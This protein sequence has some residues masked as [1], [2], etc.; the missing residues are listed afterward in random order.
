MEP[1][2]SMSAKDWLMEKTQTR[3]EIFYLLGIVAAMMFAAGYLAR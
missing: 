3:A 1:V 2:A